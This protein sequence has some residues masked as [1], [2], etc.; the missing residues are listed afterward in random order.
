[1]RPGRR[2]LSLSRASLNQHHMQRLRAV[3]AVD[4]RRS[5]ERAAA[6]VGSI[7]LVVAD[8]QLSTFTPAAS[9]WAINSS[10]A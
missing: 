3:H 10:R 1:M 2:Q 4:V 7:D 8:N 5:L 6:D 9:S